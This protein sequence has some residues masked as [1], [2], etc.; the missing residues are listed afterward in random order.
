MIP[1]ILAT[2][3]SEQTYNRCLKYVICCVYLVVN[4]QV[5]ANPVSQNWL[6]VKQKGHIK[7]HTTSDPSGYVWLKASIT[8]KGAPMDFVALLDDID[9]AANWIDNCE[10]VELLASPSAQEKIVRTIFKAPWPVKEREMITKSIT[11]MDTQQQNIKIT[12]QDYPAYSSNNHNL[13]RIQNVQG[14]WLV[15]A[16]TKNNMLIE[17]IGFGNPSGNLPI[18]LANKMM[19]SSMFKTFSNLGEI[20]GDPSS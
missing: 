13:V 18:W 17:Y 4:C 9:T 19:V 5:F 16:T 3:Q 11:E 1:K 8:V 7:V 12:I 15:K 10:K 14:Q 6:Q 2:M 20:L